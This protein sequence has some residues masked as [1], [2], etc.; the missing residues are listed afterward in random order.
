MRN[1]LARWRI[2]VRLQMATAVTLTAFAVLLISVQIM[3]SRRLYDARVSLLQSVDE[4]ATGIAAS[5]QREEAAG[6]LTRE[7][8]QTLAAAAIKA[9]RYQGAEY[10][11]INDMQPRMIM[12]PVKPELDGQILSGMADPTG[13]HLFAA[14]TELVKARGEGTLPYMW[15]KPGSEAPVPKLSYVKG[16]APWGWIIGT[17]LYVDDLEAAQRTLAKTL[18]ALGIVVSAL[19]GGMVWLLGR[20]VSKPVQALTAATRSLGDGD[21]DVAIPGQ[22]RGDEVG[23]MSKALVVLRDAAVAQRKL[24]TDIAAERAA[25]D[26]RQVAIERHTQDFGSTIV[27]V[28]AQLTQSS[29]SMHLASNEMVVSVSRTQE[30]AMATAQGARES[31]MNLS[32]VVSAAEEM[33]ASVN[34][35]SQQ[36]THVTRAAQDATDRVSLTDEK[37]LRLAQAAEQIGAVVGL[38]TNIAGQTNLLALNATIEAARAGEAGKGFAVVAGEVKILAAQTAKATDEIRGQVDAIRSATAEAVAMVS[39]VRTAIDQMDQVVGAIAAAV[40][41]QSAATREIAMNAQAVSNSTRAAVQAMDEVCAVVGASD[42]TSRNVSSEAA[43]IS[44]TSVRLREETDQFLKTMANPTDEQ[45]RQYE[46]VPG[47]GMRAVL[48]SGPRE[49]ASVVVNTISRGGVALDSDWAPPAGQAVS[50]TIGASHA[51]IQGRVIRSRE[52]VIA[53]AFG[54]DAANLALIGQALTTPGGRSLRAA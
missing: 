39:G 50:V 34:E 42:A 45:R 16:F 22:D 25:K 23:S 51:L 30:R 38:I 27:A 12:H 2:G 13:L 20:S 43:E 10:I 32:A 37:V 26:R 46:R 17:G 1:I 15:P 53:I 54:Q 19:L 5:Y 40:E 28:L 11:W 44:A 41:E 36:I 6:R 48:G 29:Q 9:M 21:L 7:A 14:M 18:L 47:N 49:G 8:A 31:A 3:E 24:E 52:G 33:S 4:A 35:I